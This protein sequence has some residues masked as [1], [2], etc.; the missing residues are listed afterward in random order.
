M[1]SWM[2]AALAAGLALAGGS[3]ASANDTVRLGGPAAQAAMS[4]ST[5]ELVRWRGGYYG[6]GYRGYYG[7]GYRGFYGGGYNRPYYN[8]FYGRPY[9]N[10]FYARPYFNNYQ[11]Y[12]SAFYPRVYSTYYSPYYCS[13]SYYAP[14]YSYPS[15]YYP[16]AGETLPAPLATMQGAPAYAAPQYT[17]PMPP[18]GNGTYPYNGG[19]NAPV[20][21][22]NAVPNQGNPP[23]PTLPIDGRL[24]SLPA[25][26]SGGVNAFGPHS[27]PAPAAPTPAPRVSYPAYGEEPI[28]PAPRRK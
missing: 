22:P 6:G 10:S 15:Y 25:T 19:P 7:G 9:Y 3:I 20:P 1:R 24:V 27:T 4:G 5:D 12:Y 21:M 17:P 11:P 2:W 18:P 26:F 14:A 8:S 13:P 28:T 16:I 23:A